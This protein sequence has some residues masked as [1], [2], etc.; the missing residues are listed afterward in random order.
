MTLAWSSSNA[1]SCTGTNFTTGG[2][3]SG[4]VKLNPTATTGYTVN[5]G[6]AT[7][8]QTVTVTSGGQADYSVK[9]VVFGS[10]PLDKT[11]ISWDIADGYVQNYTGGVTYDSG[12]QAL[13]F[14]L[15]A[16]GSYGDYAGHYEANFGSATGTDVQPQFGPGSSYDSEFYV[17]WQ[18]NMSANY[19][20]GS[21]EGGT[22]M[23]ILTSSDSQN[24]SATTEQ[25][26]D[27]MD[28]QIFATN[29]HYAGFPVMANNCGYPDGM[30]ARPYQGI[31]PA[32]N[33]GNTTLY[34]NEVNCTAS[35]TGN[36]WSF[37][38]NEWATYQ[39]HVSCP[40]DY[41]NPSEYGGSVNDNPS[42]RNY[43][44]NCIVEFHA[45]HQGQPAVNIISV[46]DYD[47]VQHVVDADC[48]S[49][50]CSQSSGTLTTPQWLAN[51]SRKSLY[52]K[53]LLIPND[54]GGASVTFPGTATAEY[55]NL[56]IGTRRFPD[57]GVSTPNAPDNLV[58]AVTGSNNLLT[59]RNNDNVS[60][61]AA[62]TSYEIWR[63][64]SGKW[65]Y[66]MNG[67]NGTWTK[68]STS[69]AASVCSGNVCAYTDSGA[70]SAL[71][72][73]RV[74]GVNASGNSAYTGTID[75][76]PGALQ[77]VTA[78]ATGSTTATLTWTLG[79]PAPVGG[80]N[81]QQCVGTYVQGSC[82]Y[83]GTWT[84][85]ASGLSPT[86]TSYNV[87][88]LT[89]GYYVWRAQAYNSFG[90]QNTWFGGFA[91]DRD[92]AWSGDSLISQVTTPSASGGT[93][94]A[95]ASLTAT[96]AS[97][98]SGGQVTL[99]WSSSNASS[100]TG[101]NFTTGG[102]ASGAVTVN[103]TATTSYTVNCGG[104]T[105]AQ[106]VTL[107]TTVG[108]T[109]TSL[110]SGTVGTS[111]SATLATSGGTTPYSWSVTVGALPGGVQLS[112]STGVISGTPTVIGTRNF[113]VQATD[114]SSRTAT[115]ALSIAVGAASG[116][117]FSQG[118]TALGSNTMAA[119]G[120]GQPQNASI[121]GGTCNAEGYPAVI[122]A[123]SG[124]TLR[125]ATNQLILFGGGH[126]DYGGNEIYALNFAVS[127]AMFQRLRDADTG[128]CTCANSSTIYLHGLP[129]VN[130]TA[131]CSENPSPNGPNSRHSYGG[132]TYIPAGQGG[133]PSGHDG[134]FIYGGSLASAGGGTGND[135]WLYDFVANTWVRKDPFTISGTG[136]YGTED[137]GTQLV[138]W[139]DSGQ[140]TALDKKIYIIDNDH[141]GRYDL[142]TNTYYPLPYAPNLGA[143]V[144]PMGAVDV[145]AKTFVDIDPNTGKWWELALDG[146][147]GQSYLN[148]PGCPTAFS[149]TP[150]VT[151][152]STRQQLV[153]WTGSGGTI[154]LYD[155]STH[156]CTDE[157]PS[158]GGPPAGNARGTFGRLQYVAG[159]DYYVVVSDSAVPAYVLCRS[160]GGC[161]Q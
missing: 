28:S 95:T 20:A 101:T 136:S 10:A 120:I 90:T 48:Q 52:G 100:C 129:P 72:S 11:G 134:I 137:V 21:G 24:A 39:L 132:L 6:G 22:K 158:A 130:A 109:T 43:H 4:T 155:T 116:S 5:C 92:G 145:H 114:S 30:Q 117:R 159:K 35:T 58:V 27:C 2:A 73:Y 41:S 25:M 66:D 3:A 14:T 64:T 148:P 18:E 65:R 102:A 31:E 49:Q 115:Q 112:S 74:R 79:N 83:H 33:G 70:G 40:S 138:S 91:W 88:G 44:H 54:T 19:L 106:T 156:S 131:V 78:T 144:A 139:Y 87:T 29:N 17:Q 157:T 23:F 8:A 7:A 108:I 151:Y 119:S 36:C 111:Y 37:A 149:E 105:A 98:S 153:I 75:N 85:I 55:R 77:N 152:D 38:A 94:P 1:S 104:A 68:I 81:V 124:G 89:A 26:A 84:T 121:S 97:V 76:L 82:D 62:T 110:P 126:N 107:P 140:N 99:A 113:T 71:Y 123:F 56:Y 154:Y 59:W 60:G 128:F 146:S 50:P 32:I 150:G 125:A 47:L 147:S 53:F 51:N 103:P 69:S 61:S 16:S 133:L 96:P 42:D 143:N 142:T 63:G 86:A 80:I 141:F 12:N 45:A 127:P 160:S 46:A 93:L 15:P 34:Q 67:G 161:A 118:W 13:L 135:A 122:E 57:P 9:R